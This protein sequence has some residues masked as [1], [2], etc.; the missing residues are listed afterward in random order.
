[1]ERSQSRRQSQAEEHTAA[2]YT[3]LSWGVQNVPDPFPQGR[4]SSNGGMRGIPSRQA[5]Y[6]ESV[7]RGGG[8]E[9]GWEGLRGFRSA[10]VS[11]RRLQETEEGEGEGEDSAREA[12]EVMEVAEHGVNEEELRARRQ[13]AVASRLVEEQLV[14]EAKER[15]KEEAARESPYSKWDHVIDMLRG[16]RKKRGLFFGWTPSFGKK[17]P[18]ELKGWDRVRHLV[19]ERRVQELG[20]GAGEK[21]ELEEKEREEEKVERVDSI[22]SDLEKG[23]TERPEV[24]EVQDV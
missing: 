22:M 21:K 3:A 17:K 18:E 10:G 20:K 11:M 24:R 2:L 15:A 5:G 12:E 16:Q 23:N 4:S 19:K 7:L 8:G 1:M 14:R 6:D 9:E 13:M